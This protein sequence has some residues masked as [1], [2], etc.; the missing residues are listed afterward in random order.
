[1]LVGI[2][3]RITINSREWMDL[4]SQSTACNCEIFLIHTWG[5]GRGARGG[6][7]RQKCTDLGPPSTYLPDN[8]I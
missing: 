4:D 3:V 2:E 7:G 6:I 1:M 8:V 5:W